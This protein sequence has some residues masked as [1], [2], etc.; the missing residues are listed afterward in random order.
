MEVIRNGKS[1]SRWACLL[2]IKLKLPTDDTKRFNVNDM[3][4]IT[5]WLTPNIAI[6]AVYEDP[7]PN[8]TDEYIKATVKNRT[9]KKYGDMISSSIR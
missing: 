6:N 9:D 1:S 4:G 5:T 8:P 7:P 3:A 2:R